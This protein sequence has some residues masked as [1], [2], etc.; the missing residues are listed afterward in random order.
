MREISGWRIGL[1]IEARSAP[2]AFEWRL[3]IKP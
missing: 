1:R 3:S 2:R